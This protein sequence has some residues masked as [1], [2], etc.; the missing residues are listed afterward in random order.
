MTTKVFRDYD[1]AALDR[2]YDNRAKVADFADYLARYPRESEKTRAELPCRL[3]VRWGPGPAATLDVF[4]P[5]P[6]AGGRPAPI[7]VFVHG[8]YWRA[9]DKADFSF[10]AQGLVPAGIAVVVVNYPLIP[11]VDMDA[12]VRHCRESVAWIHR[13]AGSFGGDPARLFVSGHSAGGHLTAMLLA[14]DWPAVAGLPPDTVKGGSGLS[15]LYDLEPIRLSYLNETLRLTHDQARRNSPVLLPPPR[16]GSLLLAVGDRE[17]PE[18]L[19]QTRDLAAAWRRAGRP[20]D[21]LEMKD[22]DHF[23]IVT[24]LEDPRSELSRAILRRMG[25]G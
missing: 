17:G 19:R 3:D 16:A 5:G 18:Y 9:L 20:C 12:L 24:Q 14:T 13:N 25:G 8:G 4:L 11:T 2:E 6:A 22:Q 23:S 21:V 1:Q 15:G 10:V 7:N